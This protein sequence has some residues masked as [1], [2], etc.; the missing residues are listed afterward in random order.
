M[1]IVN[2]NKVWR[3][4]AWQLHREDGPAV[5]FENG[6]EEW[7]FYGEKHRLDGPACIRG[8]SKIWYFHGKQHREDGPAVERVNG[9][10]EWWVHGQRHRTDGPSI[11][12][13]DRER[14]E[15]YLFGQRHR[16]DGPAVDLVIE[17]GLRYEAWYFK[18]KLHRT[19][20]PAVNDDQHTEWW[21]NGQLHRTD[22]PAVE[23]VNGDNLWYI[24]DTWVSKPEVVHRVCQQDLKVLLLTRIVNP[25]C[26]I[27]VAKYA[28]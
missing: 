25:F 10:K 20:G 15:W 18:G 9:D 22:G 3:N 4:P 8:G 27:N 28:L 23:Y 1:N 19:I 7:Y 6:D 2:G 26:E 12:H 24:L 14:R 21:K 17:N 13:D 11:E 16:E 5:E